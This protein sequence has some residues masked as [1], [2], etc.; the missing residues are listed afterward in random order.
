[1]DLSTWLEDKQIM[2]T[3]IKQH[4]QRAQ[5]RMKAQADKK[6]FE[7]SFSEGDWVYLKLQRYVQSSLAPHANQKLA[8]KFFGPFQVEA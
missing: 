7:R 6:R 2:Q 1:M 4:L 8:F 5:E 3:L